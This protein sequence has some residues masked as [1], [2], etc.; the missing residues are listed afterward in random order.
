MK[1]LRLYPILRG[2]FGTQSPEDAP[3]QCLNCGTTLA[4]QYQEC[5]E[6]GSYTIDR[7]DWLNDDS[8]G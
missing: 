6:C 1:S 8:V 3:Y 7:V 4:L 5:P 2:I